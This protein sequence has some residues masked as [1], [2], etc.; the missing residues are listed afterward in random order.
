MTK[1]EQLKARANVIELLEEEIEKHERTIESYRDQ[2][3]Q[4]MK[5]WEIKELTNASDKIER[6]KY[7]I[8]EL[9]K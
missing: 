5:N 1:V 7:I 9:A 2:K 8:E 3:P 4:D 6:F